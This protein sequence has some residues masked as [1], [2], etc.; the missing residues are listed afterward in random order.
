MFNIA[1]DNFA[2]FDDTVTDTAAMSM[3]HS[4]NPFPWDILFHGLNFPRQKK[5]VASVG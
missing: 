1:M 5:P 4:P 2:T 3:R